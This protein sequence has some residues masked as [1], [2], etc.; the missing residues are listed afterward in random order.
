MKQYYGYGKAEQKDDAITSAL[1]GLFS[2]IIFLVI[3]F[4]LGRSL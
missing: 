1:L 4:I 3:G 2:I